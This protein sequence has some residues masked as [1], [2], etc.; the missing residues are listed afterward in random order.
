MTGFTRARMFVA[1]L[2]L[3][4][5][6][7]CAAAP[8]EEVPLPP[9]TAE[10]WGDAGDEG[11]AAEL[12]WIVSRTALASSPPRSASAEEAALL[13][14]AEAKRSAEPEEAPSSQPA[15]STEPKVTL[16]RVVSMRS[17]EEETK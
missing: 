2:A 6:Q 16:R 9:I 7:G 17:S 3:T 14:P 5:L 10:L 12:D 15:P 13:E 1:L 8:V 4:L 11:L